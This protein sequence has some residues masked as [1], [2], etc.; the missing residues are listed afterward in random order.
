MTNILISSLNIH[1]YVHLQKLG[2]KAQDT[3]ELFFEDCRI[4]ADALLGEEGKGFAYLMQE[5]PQERLLVA[6][7]ALASAEAC[8]EWTR[9]FLK[10]RIAFGKPLTDKQV[11]LSLRLKGI[12]LHTVIW[13][14]ALD[15]SGALQP[16]SV[17]SLASHITPY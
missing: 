10:D 3:S 11:S 5:L 7:M 9:T 1:L 8:F 13:S 12:F 17:T 2:M 15:G 16:Y 14:G 4:P 6:E